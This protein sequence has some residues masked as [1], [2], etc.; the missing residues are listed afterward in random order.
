M[1][2][3]LEEA[4]LT[5]TVLRGVDLSYANLS[6]K[7]DLKGQDLGGVRLVEAH[8]GCDLSGTDLGGTRTFPA[9]TSRAPR[10][11]ALT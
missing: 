6:E 4:D 8:A 9:P 1:G 7:R 10:W 2:A 11:R 5:A 3:S